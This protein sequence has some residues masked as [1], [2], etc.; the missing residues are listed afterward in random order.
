[1]NLKISAL[2][3]YVTPL[4]ADVFAIVDTANTTTKKISWATIKSFLIGSGK[5]TEVTGTSASMAIN[6]QYIANNAAVVTL[7]LPTTAAVGDMVEI[8]GEG[9]GGWLLAQ[10]AS[11][12][13][14]YGNVSTTVGTGGKIESTHRRNCLK[15]VCVTA[16]TDWQ[17]VHAVG[18]LIVT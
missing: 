2:T 16:N 12:V 9:A 3:N 14:Y 13:I 17:V 8:I 5:T 11:Q 4:D 15:L 1:M 6:K 18:T 7:T 10:N